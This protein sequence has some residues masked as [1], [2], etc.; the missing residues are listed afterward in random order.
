MYSVVAFN[1]FC[2][3]F[4]GEQDGNSVFFI[5]AVDEQLLESQKKLPSSIQVSGCKWDHGRYMV[6]IVKDMK[7]K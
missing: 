1:L 5:S 6:R 2:T 7:G 3:M 4:F